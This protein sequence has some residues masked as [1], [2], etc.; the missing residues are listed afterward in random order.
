VRAYFVALGLATLFVGL[1]LLI[2]GYVR[3]GCTVNSSGGTPVYTNC[4]GADALEFVGAIL[5][6]I[7]VLFVAASFVPNDRSRY[8]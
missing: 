5:V 8:K 2:A 6:V 4:G 7:A 1:P 3:V